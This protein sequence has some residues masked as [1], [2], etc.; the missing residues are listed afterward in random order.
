M[1]K[2]ILVVDDEQECAL[3]LKLGLEATGC[4]VVEQEHDALAAVESARVFDP[5]LIVLDVMMPD[6]DGGEVAARLRADHVL[7]EV[8]VIFLTALVSRAD[9]FANPLGVACAGHTF[10]PK[11]APLRQI[12]DCIESHWAGRAL[13]PPLGFDM[14]AIRA[15]AGAT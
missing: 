2:R 1:K 8:P 15:H 6:L 13:P 10:L 7:H 14:H 4:Y 9:V 3:V 11:G 12:I 5:D